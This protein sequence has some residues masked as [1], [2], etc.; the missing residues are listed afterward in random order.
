MDMVIETETAKM[1]DKNVRYIWTLASRSGELAGDA[2]PRS[3]AP[4]TKAS[5][6][7]VL[8]TMMGNSRP[9]MLDLKESG[10]IEN[11][12]HVVGSVLTSCC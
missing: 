2:T 10:D 4:T 3:T 7:R 8:G 11:H 12:S 5:M 9:T 1:E 6:R